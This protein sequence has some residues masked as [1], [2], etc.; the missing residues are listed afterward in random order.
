M[1]KGGKTGK[2][3]REG[4]QVGFFKKREQETGFLAQTCCL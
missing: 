4:D 2:G 1:L 3:K